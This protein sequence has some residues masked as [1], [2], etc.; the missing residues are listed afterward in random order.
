MKHQGESDEGAHT[1]AK[2]PLLSASHADRITSIQSAT[3]SQSILPDAR[4][5]PPHRIPAKQTHTTHTRA[6]ERPEGGARRERE[7]KQNQHAGGRPPAALCAR[8]RAGAATHG[9][10][11]VGICTAGQH[12]ISSSSSSSSRSRTRR[13]RR[14]RRPRRRRRR[15][16]APAPPSRFTALLDVARHRRGALAARRS[17]RVG[18]ASAQPPPRHLPRL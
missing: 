9:V 16:P 12:R 4:R 11:P 6:K 14:R 17:A 3:P 7:Q 1:K 15:P 10:E 5:I 13:R 8:L 18:S 2:R